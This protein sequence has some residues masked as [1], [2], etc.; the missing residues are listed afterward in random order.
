MK[1]RKKDETDAEYIERLET[2]L[3][4]LKATND[5]FRKDHARIYKSLIPSAQVAGMV[6]AAAAEVCGVTDDPQVAVALEKLQALGSA[7]CNDDEV[8]FDRTIDWPAPVKDYGGDAEMV[9]KSALE[10]V[11]GTVP[12]WV[13]RTDLFPYVPK[14]KPE[15]LNWDELHWAVCEALDQLEFSRGFLRLD[16]RSAM[17]D[18]CFQSILEAVSVGR[19]RQ[20]KR[21]EAERPYDDTAPA[22]PF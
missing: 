9:L 12:P 10:K 20:E 3:R 16:M 5:R 7:H 4:G 2:S 6:C 8:T 15:D 14:T 17:Y 11:K 21:A 18:H 19:A 22:I 13:H 1:P